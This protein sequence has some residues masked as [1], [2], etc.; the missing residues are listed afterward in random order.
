[1]A[2][3]VTEKDSQQ[4]SVDQQTTGASAPV[5]EDD[6][7]P[8]GYEVGNAAPATVYEDQDGKI[9]RG[10]PDGGFRGRVLV[11]QGDTVTRFIADRLA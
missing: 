3:R 4:T 5:P 1:M 8:E 9:V 7:R 10:E 11:A 2:R 6:L